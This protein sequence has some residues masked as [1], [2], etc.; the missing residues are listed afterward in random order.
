MNAQ[1]SQHISL[2]IFFRLDSIS[3]GD[4]LGSHFHAVSIIFRTRNLAEHCTISEPQDT[5]NDVSEPHKIRRSPDFE[6]LKLRK[7]RSGNA[8]DLFSGMVRA[9]FPISGRREGRHL[10]YVKGQTRPTFSQ[11][12][13]FEICSKTSVGGF[14]GSDFFF[15]NCDLIGRGTHSAQGFYWLTA[16]TSS[17]FFFFI[18]KAL[19][20]IFAPFEIMTTEEPMITGFFFHDKPIGAK[21]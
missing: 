13:T 19:P 11:L 21:F 14:W 15:W 10:P 2:H 12:L 9:F 3:P 1:R 8:A 6:A 7:D 4:Y 20:A 18:P 5:S 17:I 16:K